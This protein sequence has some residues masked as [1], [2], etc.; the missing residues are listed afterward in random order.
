MNNF[1]N[2]LFVSHFF[3]QMKFTIYYYGSDIDYL[4]IA[5]PG[6]DSFIIGGFGFKQNSFSC[7]NESYYE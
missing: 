4:F 7:R 2:K 3:L 5:L 1:F 6:F